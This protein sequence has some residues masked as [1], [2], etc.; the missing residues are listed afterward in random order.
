MG[1]GAR[2]LN[3]AAHFPPTGD[4]AFRSSLIEVA[5]KNDTGATAYP[6]NMIHIERALL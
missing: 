5:L 6:L 3:G 1:A 2:L 4:S